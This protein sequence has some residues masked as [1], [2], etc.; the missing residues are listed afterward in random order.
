MCKKDKDNGDGKMM[1][2]KTPDTYSDVPSEASA[3]IQLPPAVSTGC[4]YITECCQSNVFAV[5][6]T[7]CLTHPHI[8]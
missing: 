3:P 6:E 4:P 2:M 5:Q 1:K 8:S 7:I